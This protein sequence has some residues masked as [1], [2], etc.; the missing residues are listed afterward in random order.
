MVNENL[1]KERDL[2][3]PL[4]QYYENELSRARARVKQI[5]ENN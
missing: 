1:K 3:I 5:D 2:L 4:I